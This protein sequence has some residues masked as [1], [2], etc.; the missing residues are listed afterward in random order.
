MADL[1][2]HVLV[3]YSLAT[4]LSWRYEWLTPQFVTVAMVGA[5]IPDLNRL[6]LI[7]PADFIEAVF[8]IPFD[9]GAVHVLGGSLL[10]VAIGTVL[11]PTTIRRRVGA[12]LLLGLTSHLTLDLL[13]LNVSGYS[14]AVLWPVAGYH[15]PSPDLYLSTDRWPAI[16]GVV[17]AASVWY[18]RFRR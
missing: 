2:T 4:L 14:Y 17:L 8:G 6:D 12:L 11:A 13:L 9:W 3:A 1:L 5:M 18:A 16:C 7:L 10:V 15:P